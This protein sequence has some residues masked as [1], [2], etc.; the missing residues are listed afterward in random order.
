MDDMEKLAC[1]NY[2]K[3]MNFILINDWVPSS[4]FPQLITALI[5]FWPLG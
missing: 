5:R 4:T 3:T 1:A 2:I